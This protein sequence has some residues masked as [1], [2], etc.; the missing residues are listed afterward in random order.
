MDDL[1]I[2]PSREAEVFDYAS[3]PE[4]DGCHFYGGWFYLVGEMI[5]AGERNTEC[6]DGHESSFWLSDQCPDSPAV[7]GLPATMIVEFT[8]HVKWVLP[9][10]ASIEGRFQSGAD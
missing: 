2:N 6:S 7:R 1:G 5:T 8:A 9:E 10:R 4:E 3:S